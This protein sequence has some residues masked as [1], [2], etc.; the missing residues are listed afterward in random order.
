[1]S[2]RST[3]NTAACTAAD[4]RDGPKGRRTR[5]RTC[6]VGKGDPRQACFRMRVEA[7]VCEM[8]AGPTPRENAGRPS[9]QRRLARLC[10][11]LAQGAGQISYKEY[12]RRIL[13]PRS[14]EHHSAG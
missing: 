6:G 9:R 14:V 13:T 7:H 11:A 5:R 8:F 12:R 3:S 10:M 1:M 4:A 2:L